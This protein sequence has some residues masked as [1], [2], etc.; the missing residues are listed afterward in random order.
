MKKAIKPTEIPRNRELYADK[1]LTQLSSFIVD[2]LREGYSEKIA[3]RSA[4]SV[5]NCLALNFSG[6]NCYIPS[7][8][9]MRRLQSTKAIIAEF[10]GVNHKDLA[11]KHGVSIVT[12]Y[13]VLKR[14]KPQNVM[15]TEKKTCFVEV[16]EDQLPQLLIQAGLQD[17]AAHTLKDQI[18]NFF[19]EN[20][21]GI[22]INFYQYHLTTNP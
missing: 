8:S 14:A 22:F 7:R 4:K 19:S 21:S 10:N 3:L 6:V 18:I 12:V 16:I 20:Y 5:I 15:L 2:Q 1:I 17:A 9:T 11:I 13:K